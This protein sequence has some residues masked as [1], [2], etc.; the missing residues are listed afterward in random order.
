MYNSRIM[1]KVKNNL[2]KKQSS[3]KRVNNYS[4]IKI[5]GKKHR[6]GVV[7]ISV[8]ALCS[9]LFALYFIGF[10]STVKQDAS[11]EIASGATVSGVARQLKSQDL[12]ESED[13]F[14]SMVAG[15]GG[16]VQSGIYDIPARSGTW[17]IAKMIAH[18]E[19]AATKIMIPEGLTVRQIYAV[20]DANPF[21]RGA[22]CEQESDCY[23]DGEL[24]PDTYRVAKGTNR[25]AVLMLM[26]KKMMTFE[27][28]WTAGGRKAPRP[29]KNWNDV[30]T[31]A[32]IVQ[33]ETPKASEMPMVASVYLNRLRKKM[34][35][36]ADP[37][38]VY[39]LT[40]RL[41]DMRGEA[42]LSGH[43]Q[44]DSPYN[45]YKNYGLPPHPIANVGS[46]AIRAVLNPSDTNYLFF[47]ADGAGGHIFSRSYGE[48]QEHHAKW[49]K[50]KKARQ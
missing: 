41:G 23:K 20:L 26:R 7:I 47:V 49:R 30:V 50:I 40:N 4:A 21:L 18:G 16:R 39:A 31:L 36:Q 28:G 8:F 43:L 33:K 44:T 3:N 29:L 24:F 1:K 12:I 35:L 27:K 15:F 22:A 13:M 6:L 19:V 46:D 2:G 37:T 11:I 48:H 10:Q 42:L 14:V 25:A 9:L 45:T 17:R 5:F 38:V 32:S 34:K